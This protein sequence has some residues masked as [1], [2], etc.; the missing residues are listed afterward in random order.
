MSNEGVELEVYGYA[1]PLEQ[2]GTFRG[3]ITPKV[4][5]EIKN[6]GGGSFNIS[7]QDKQIVDHPEWLKSRNVVKHRVDGEVIG[8][9]LIGNRG[10]TTISESSS[11]EVYEIAGEG[12]KSWLDD[13]LVHPLGGFRTTSR[14]A[15]A[16]SFASEEGDW[17]NPSEWIEPYQIQR[18]RGKLWQYGPDK[19]PDGAGSAYWVWGVPDSGNWGTDHGT[20]YFRISFPVATP[21]EYVLYVAVDDSYSV[22]L[23]GEQVAR[24]EDKFDGW[25]EAKK[26]TLQLEAGDH[27]IGIRATNTQY[28]GGLAAALYRTI[29]RQPPVSVG[30]VTIPIGTTPTITRSNHG[31]SSGT[32]VYL[33][34]TGT[35]PGG[36]E[37]DKNYYVT[38]STTNTFK[39]SKS[40]GG[41]TLNTSGSQSG[42]HTILRSEIADTEVL[43]TY[44]GMK[45]STLTSLLS[46]Y[47]STVNIR[48]STY[49]GLPSGSKTGSATQKRQARAKAN[50]LALLQKARQARDRIQLQL[51]AAINAD[52]AGI[53]WRVLPYPDK[54]PGWSPGEIL[55]TLLGEAADRGVISAGL[56]TPNFTSLVDSE[57]EPWDEPIDWSFSVGKDSLLAVVSQMEELACD[58]WIDP[59]TYELNVVN[60]RGIDR[61]DYVGD[62]NWVVIKKNLA[63]TPVGKM[64]AD[65]WSTHN[66]LTSVEA[67]P[68]S[69]ISGA[70]GGIRTA[71]G[72]TAIYSHRGT[73]KQITFLGGVTYAISG[74]AY[75]DI[76]ASVRFR[77]NLASTTNGGANLDATLTPNTWTRLELSYTPIVDEELNISLLW[78]NGN[79][80]D[81]IAL[82]GI[83]VEEGE[84]ASDYIDGFMVGSSLTRYRWEGVEN[85]SITSME[86]QGI[87]GSP[88]IFKAG[89]N[90]R[91]ASIKSRGKIKNSLTIKGDQGWFGDPEIDNTSAIE[92]GVLE[93]VLD[94]GASQAVS[95]ALAGIVFVQRAQEEEGAS[96]DVY[97]PPEGK[98]PHIDFSVGDWVLAPNEQGLSVKR[99]IMSISTEENS[100]GRPV[101]TLEFDTIFRDNEDRINRV[102]EKLGGN[103]I[104]SS[105]SNAGGVGSPSPSGPTDLPPTEGGGLVDITPLAPTDL[106]VFSIGYWSANGVTAY[107]Q[108]N[109]SWFPVVEAVDG[110]EIIPSRYEVWGRPTEETEDAISMM[111]ST[112]Q[113]MVTIDG[114]EPGSG[115]TF[116]VIAWSDT[117]ASDRSEEILHTIAGPVEPMVAPSQAGGFSDKG[118]IVMQ[119]D[120]LMSDGEPPPLQFRY[121]YAE[122]RAAGST[123]GWLQLG[124]TLGRDGR[125]ITLSGLPVGYIFEARYIA[126]DGS[127]IKSAPGIVSNPITVMGVDL[128]DLDEQVTEA[129]E[130]AKEAGIAARE[131][132]NMLNDPSFELNTQE[133]WTYGTGV[134]N[135]NTAPRTGLRHLLLAAG[136]ARQ[137]LSYNRVLPCEPG[138]NFYIR[139]F[140]D[141]QGTPASDDQVTLQVRYGATEALGSIENA[142][143]SG[144]LDG[145]GYQM[146]SGSWEVPPGINYFSLSVGQ[147]ADTISYYADDFRLLKMTGEIDLVAGSVTTDKIASESIV[148]RHIQAETI[149]SEH[150]QAESIGTRELAAESVVA[151]KLAAGSVET[152]HISAGAV[153]TSHISSEVG[154]E[155]DIQN[156]SSINLV[157]GQIGDVQGDLDS[158]NDNLE[159]MQ[160]YYQ[161][162]AEGAVISKPGSVFATRIDNDSID[163]L[164]NGNVISYWNSGTLYV[165]QL[166]GE[167][168]TLGNH[169][170][171]KFEDGTV[172]RSLGV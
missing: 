155:L 40:K 29:A 27:V 36:L 157:V 146:V 53:T 140:I 81:L 90:L 74:Y 6:V 79:P 167:S 51:T 144:P 19:W 100:S 84:V 161:F 98:T 104:G 116:F 111:A 31:L 68:P 166:V 147:E 118:L 94:T 97:L 24:Y 148:G 16:F 91:K 112:T 89:K 169:Q 172:I 158:T 39:L 103:G 126:V 87:I 149:A 102:L 168:V 23:D 106:E 26:V 33:T 47:Q 20:N 110:E 56:I 139:L 114:F 109:L 41:P 153:T 21:A 75:S 13:S 69:G 4:L 7:S 108:V 127:G 1:N 130:A 99:R 142:V 152:N 163:M 165:N 83:Q 115:W 138:D 132:S 121:L 3:A 77:A 64:G 164:E 78:N 117:R 170:L 49:N 32:R 50:A 122:I 123:G 124:Q 17:Y 136:G 145:V 86:T 8:G 10:A 52:A 28:A 65:S 38:Q 154:Q 54:A 133:F 159:L 73:G 58:V 59:E 135:V 162:G 92:Y 48:Q 70:L 66:F 120:G 12:L 156:N 9:W 61:S 141:P 11:G 5:E 129:I 60:R 34:T 44:S 25:Q 46:S 96:Y 42:T 2:I 171:A 72:G 37:P 15:R 67:T 82:T 43:V 76:A 151:E 113:P 105:Y 125:Q 63:R 71:T 35:L 30:T 160:T 131:Q 119:W 95:R 22:Y 88:I 137:S 85:Q 18:I 62:N 55:I 45:V 150:I 93:G 128:G 101:Y 14:D 134:T 80:G 57:G 107:G 143:S